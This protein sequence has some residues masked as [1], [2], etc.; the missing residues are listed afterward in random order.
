[1]QG[2]AGSTG[3][4]GLAGSTGLQGLAGSTGLQGI[5]GSTGLQG[6]A[7][8]T[9]LQGIAGSTGLQG[10]AGSTG[11]QGLAGLQGH[12]GIQGSTGLQ[13]LAGLQGH[14]GI[15][16]STGGI[17]SFSVGCGPNSN[18][19][20]AVTIYPDID[21]IIFDSSADFIVTSDASNVAFVTNNTFKYW[22]ANGNTGPG[23]FL[24]A[25]GV[26][27]VNFAGNNGI[28]ITMNPNVNPQR[29]N[30]GLTDITTGTINADGLISALNGLYVSGNV[31]INGSCTA[32][33]FS[34]ALSGNATTAT[35]AT[36]INLISNNENQ[37]CY[38]PFS[39]TATTSSTLYIDN[40]TS[41][42]SY[43]PSTSTLTATNFNGN[44]ST[45][46]TATTATNIG[47][48]VNNDNQTCYIPFSKTSGTSNTLY[49]DNT[50][51]VLSYNPNTSTLTATNFSGNASTATTATNIAGGSNYSIPYQS[52]SNSTTFLSASAE[53]SGYYF[54]VSGG[55]SAPP[56][57]RNIVIFETGWTYVTT[58]TSSIQFNSDLI[59]ITNLPSV[60]VLFATTYPNPSTVYD[61]TGQGINS[62]FDQSYIV[63]FINGHFYVKTGDLHVALYYNGN[64][65]V[66][67]NVGYYNIRLRY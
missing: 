5:A 67:A 26:D 22:E 43:N 33:S 56:S 44:A 34:G 6:L 15:Q 37:T 61:I 23:T 60:Q 63:Y 12:T 38:I 31:N 64:T 1:L 13:G 45:A 20:E 52:S 10:I 48:T 54:L 51:S 41:V 29:V 30:I 7:G 4:Q 2:I 62:N 65:A 19:D 21:T 24:T 40:T 9:G 27:T 36:T 46:T 14:T 39:K 25:N 3:L 17:I 47:L 53:N 32:S 16:G 35:T 8:S 49:I 57:W 42:L 11:L 28:S 50:T 66:S 59:D 55:T 58:N 18:I